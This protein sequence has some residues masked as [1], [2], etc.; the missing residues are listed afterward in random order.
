MKFVL[1]NWGTRGEVEPFAAI[2][3]ELVRRGHDVHLVVAPEMVGFAE[4]AG[5]QAVAFGPSLRVADDPHH[6]YW[7]LLNKKPWK[8]RTLNKLLAEFATPLNEYRQ[9][10]EKTL[11]SLSD[12]ADVLLTG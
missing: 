9:Q 2:G 7:K 12:G 1:A 11:L 10:V 4:S 6:E 5:T 8:L 3:R